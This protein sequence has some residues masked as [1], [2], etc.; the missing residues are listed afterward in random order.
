MQYQEAV[1]ALNRLTAEKHYWRSML[2]RLTDESD[3]R[4]AERSEKINRVE[5]NIDREL[6]EA[7]TLRQQILDAVN[8]IVDDS[9]RLI[10]KLRY[11]EGYSWVKIVMETHFSERHVY[12]LHN[13]GIKS[14]QV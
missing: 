14:M 8:S 2:A 5:Q 6:D 13:Y 12:R 11:L 7:V 3:P 4:F 10:V 9:Q 1:R